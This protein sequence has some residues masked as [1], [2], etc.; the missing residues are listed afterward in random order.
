MP[1][2]P[3]AALSQTK[4]AAN[5]VLLTVSGPEQLPWYVEHNS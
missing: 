5:A 3:L 1:S 4:F 2:T